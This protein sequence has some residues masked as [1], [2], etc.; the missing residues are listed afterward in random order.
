MTR[1]AA[2]PPSPLDPPR[3]CAMES[4]S[5]KNSTQG[6]AARAFS[7]TSRTLA[8]DSP[9]HIVR[10]SGPG[11]FYGAGG[12]QGILVRENQMRN[13]H[14]PGWHA[15]IGER[16]AFYLLLNSVRTD[17]QYRLLLTSPADL[18]RPV[19][20]LVFLILSFV[21]CQKNTVLKLIERHH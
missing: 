14:K 7:K 2:P 4:S 5:S 16:V 1:S 20:C 12:H 19:P 17:H 21:T 10:S 18:S 13:R 15:F 8:S 11:R 3:F 6:A 9:N